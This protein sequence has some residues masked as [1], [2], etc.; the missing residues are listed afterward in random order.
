MVSV[1]DMAPDF[2]LMAFDKNMVRLSDSIGNRVVLLFY[3]AAFTGVCTK[4]ICTFSDSMNRMETAEAEVFGISVDG[5][6]AN[7]AFADAND[8]SFP[9]L[10]DTNRQ[11]TRAYEVEIPFVM[12]DY[13]ASQRSVFVIDEVGKISYAWVAENPGIEPDYEAILEHLES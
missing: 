9:L 12:P 8:I 10:S 2:E 13:T 5:I 4:E 7:A 6:F 11:A 3:P 1:G